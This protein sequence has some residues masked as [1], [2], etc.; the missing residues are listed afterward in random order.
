MNRGPR[1]LFPTVNGTWLDH[2]NEA[3]AEHPEDITLPG[4]VEDFVEPEPDALITTFLPI[5]L[6]YVS[7]TPSAASG[8]SMSTV[9]SV[10]VGAGA[11]GGAGGGGGGVS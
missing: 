7:A 8:S 3:L 2:L 5:Y 1:F 11:V 9:S 10:S 4:W 6:I